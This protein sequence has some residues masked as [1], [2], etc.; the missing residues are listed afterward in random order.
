MSG[1]EFTR[2]YERPRT[3]IQITN[4]LFYE[5]KCFPGIMTYCNFHSS[6]VKFF[7]CLNVN[8]TKKKWFHFLSGRMP[9]DESRGSLHILSEQRILSFDWSKHNISQPCRDVIMSAFVWSFDRRPTMREVL[10]LAWFHNKPATSRPVTVSSSSRR[11]GLPIP[12][13]KRTASAQGPGHCS[14]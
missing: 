5:F 1:S 13:I 10:S 3:D 4:A 8:L 7:P 11:L 9:F 2:N 6:H 12:R 14:I